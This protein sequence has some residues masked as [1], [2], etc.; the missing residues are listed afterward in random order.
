MQLL[1]MFNKVIYNKQNV[2]AMMISG[3]RRYNLYKC[4]Y[5]VISSM[6]KKKH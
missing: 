2:Q 5:H 6:G 3:K 4:I 1:K